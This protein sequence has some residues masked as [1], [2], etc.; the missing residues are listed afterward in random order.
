MFSMVLV[1]TAEML[2][3]EHLGMVSRPESSSAEADEAVEAVSEPGSPC[4]CNTF[5]GSTGLRDVITRFAFLRPAAA[6]AASALFG[7]IVFFM[8]AVV[9]NGKL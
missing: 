7:D 2:P 9:P 8:F 6:S 5:S 4:C 1:M 3:K